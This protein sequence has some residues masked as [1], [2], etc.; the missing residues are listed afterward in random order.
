M[1]LWQK[2]PNFMTFLWHFRQILW[3]FYDILTSFHSYFMIFCNIIMLRFKDVVFP[4]F[5]QPEVRALSNLPEAHRFWEYFNRGLRIV[6]SLFL[7]RGTEN[8]MISVIHVNESKVKKKYG[9]RNW[10]KGADKSPTPGGMGFRDKAPGSWA[11]LLSTY[12]DWSGL[13]MALHAFFKEIGRSK[14]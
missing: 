6:F 14:L 2:M 10:S 9:L 4:G 11:I 12:Q 7:W 5:K 13:K 1:I 8:D 3:L